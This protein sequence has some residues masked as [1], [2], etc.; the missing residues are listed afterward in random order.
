MPVWLIRVLPW[1]KNRLINFVVYAII[2][3]FVW[4]VYSKIFLKET[5]KTVI[6][7]GGQQINN[8]DTP[9]TN[10]FNFG[11]SNLQIDAYWKKVRNTK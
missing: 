10:L 8:Y 4:G 2:G 1:A 9:K 6:S 11:C 7:S 5:H 3:I